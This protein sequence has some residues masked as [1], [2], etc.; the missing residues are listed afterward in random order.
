[1]R[2]AD[3]PAAGWYPDPQGGTRLRWWD[4]TDWSDRWRSRPAPPLTMGPGAP[5]DGQFVDTLG[6]AV[7]SAGRSVSAAG[8]RPPRVGQRERVEQVRQATR[9]EMARGADLLGQQARQATRQLEPLI[10][11]YTN[12]LTALVRRLLFIVVAVLVFW[13]VFRAVAEATFF[14]WLGDRI[15]S[16][17]GDSALPRGPSPT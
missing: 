14:E 5:S 11:Q 16:L 13:F 12:R 6:D 1:M 17:F 15:D 2:R 9:A 4:G 7:R 10:S 8:L 3:A